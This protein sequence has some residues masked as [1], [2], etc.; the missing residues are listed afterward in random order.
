MLRQLLNMSPDLLFQDHVLGRLN[1]KEDE[2]TNCS[3]VYTISVD[4]SLLVN[5]T[6]YTVQLLGSVSTGLMWFFLERYTGLRETP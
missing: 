5:F 3:V 1:I 4:I 6:E 2:S